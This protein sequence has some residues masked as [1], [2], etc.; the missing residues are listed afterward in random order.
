MRCSARG[1]ETSIRKELLE[2][3]A[4]ELQGSAKQQGDALNKAVLA[5]LKGL[6]KL[7]KA[8]AKGDIASASAALK[9]HVLEFVALE[10]ERLVE[11]FGVS[12]IGGELT[13]L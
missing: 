11:K 9:G 4:K 2:A 13:D 5:D 10:P 7:A 8:S 3:A 6:D 12:D 1:W